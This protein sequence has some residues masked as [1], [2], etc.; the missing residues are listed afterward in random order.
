VRSRSPSLSGSD[1]RLALVLG[2]GL[3]SKLEVG[4]VLFLVVF[5]N[6]HVYRFSFVL[7][8]VFAFVSL[9]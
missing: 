8:F 7:Q 5:Q 9:A 6:F 4:L 3:L 1:A 2:A